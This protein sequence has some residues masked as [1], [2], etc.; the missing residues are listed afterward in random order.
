MKNNTVFVLLS[1]GKSERMGVPK[2]LLEYKNSFWII[3]QIDRIAATTITEVYIGLAYHS[4][5]YLTKIPLL[6]K[7][8]SGLVYYKKIK[9]RVIINKNPELGSFSTLQN[10]LQYIPKNKSV[11]I[12]TIDV[13]LLNTS[14]L[15]RII[16]S[17]NQII[18]PNFEGKKGH[19]VKLCFDFWKGLLLLDSKNENSRLD[20]EI[21]KINPS[22]MTTISVNDSCITKNLNTPEDWLEYLKNT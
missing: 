2:G 15:Q 18:F 1:G 13:P 16:D 6:K 4:E 19:P 9:I 10:V 14:E 11:L 21:K 8:L 3:E 22:E 5:E 12:N 17:Q 7:A 20:F